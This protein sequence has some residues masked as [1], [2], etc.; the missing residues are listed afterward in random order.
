MTPSIHSARR[1]VHS[2]ENEAL[3]PLLLEKLVEG[4]LCTGEDVG[5]QGGAGL[6]R[7]AEIKLGDLQ[8]EWDTDVCEKAPAR[9]PQD[10]VDFFPIH[11]CDTVYF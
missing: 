9:L 7:A 2:P 8:N 3:G 1:G 11:K 10:T 5:R 6:P 4:P